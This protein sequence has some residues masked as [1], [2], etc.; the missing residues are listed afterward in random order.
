MDDLLLQ[1]EEG[2]EDEHEELLENFEESMLVEDTKSEHTVRNYG[3][4][5]KAFLLWCEHN[6]LD[7]LTLDYKKFRRYLRELE[8][9]KY[10]KTTQNRHLSAI[11][12]F[13]KHLNV[14]GITK[15]NP[16]AELS[17]PKKEAKLPRVMKTGEIA[18]LLDAVDGDEPANK[19]DLALLEFIYACGARVSEVSNLR[20]QDVDF[21]E[22]QVS[23]FG[24]GSK[25]RIVPLHKLCIK[26][27]KD[28]LKVRGEL[29]PAGDYFFVSNRGNQYSTNAIRTMFKNAL[30]KAGLDLSYTPHTLRH[31]FA[32]DV[33]SGG[34][35]LRSVQ[36]MLGHA[37]LSTTQIYTHISPERLSEVHHQAHPRG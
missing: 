36:E 10:T 34:A 7:P 24:K 11:R 1:F 21:A 17:G 30:M 14:A 25:E 20:L 19:R 37:N 18:K 6:E 12:T 4:D 2:L 22:K 33:L 15:I 26:E 27:L 8:Q 31:S 16:A 32:T 3:V 9:A 13:Y 28:Y 23:L 35:D 29:D 5:V